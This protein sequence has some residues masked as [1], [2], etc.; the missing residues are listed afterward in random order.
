MHFE[1][2]LKHLKIASDMLYKYEGREWQQLFV[3]GADFPS[4]IKLK[5]NIA[6]VREV[7]N[8]V[9]KTGYKEN[10]IKIDD[11]PDSADYFKY[12]RQV[13]SSVSQVASHNVIEK[14]IS[15]KGQDYRFET[16]PNPEKTLR[17]R[18]VDNTDLGRKKGY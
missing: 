2:E 10:T 17:D 8:T 5:S 1:E 11:M 14:Y 18:K 6:Y 7:I 3:G 12:Q 15:K 13:N 4:L 16:K 9:R